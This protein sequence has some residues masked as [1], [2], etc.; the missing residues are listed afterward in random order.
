[1]LKFWFF[2]Y[3]IFFLPL[4]WL[5]FRILSLFNPKIR[6]GF[7]GR[8]RIYEDIKGWDLKDSKKKI[9]FHSSSLGEY[10][11]AIPIITE[12]L[13]K[14]YQIIST[15]FSPSGYKNSKNIV[16]RCLQILHTIRFIPKR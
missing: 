3:N 2:V 10:Q 14:D 16:T 11:Q 5:G 15:F 6:E 8:K 13:Q 1:M 12:L 4:I 9:I 7:K